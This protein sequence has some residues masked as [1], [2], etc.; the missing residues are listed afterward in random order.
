M[1]LQ[2]FGWTIWD[3][4]GLDPV[5]MPDFGDACCAD[6]RHIVMGSVTQRCGGRLRRITHHCC[7]A[8][9]TLYRDPITGKY[10]HWGPK[11]HCETRNADGRCALFAA[12][13]AEEPE[14][15]E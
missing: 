11:P 7:T 9:C 4:R 3:S 15:R 2:L 5:P 10:G 6:C 8:T 14:E 13:D 1:K 12:K